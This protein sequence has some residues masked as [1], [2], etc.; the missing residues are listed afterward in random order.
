[1]NENLRNCPH[2]GA[3]MRLIATHDE[4]HPVE[5]WATLWTAYSFCVSCGMRTGDFPGAT[6][7]EVR[8]KAADVS[9][10]RVNEAAFEMVKVEN[11]R[12]IDSEEK[13]GVLEK[14]RDEWKSKVEKLEKEIKTLS[15]IEDQRQMA[16]SD[17]D[18]WKTEAAKSWEV[19]ATLNTTAE[20]KEK[21]RT[22]L[23]KILDGVIISLGGRPEI[24]LPSFWE[25]LP[26]LVKKLKGERD[27]WKAKAEK[28]QIYGSDTTIRCE[29]FEKLLDGVAEAIKETDSDR[30]CSWLDLPARVKQLR[31]EHHLACQYAKEAESKR[32][33][34]YEEASVLSKQLIATK[35]ERD[36]WKVKAEKRFFLRRSVESQK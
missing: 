26:D 15:I 9:N 12:A 11:Q 13:V 28:S 1:M 36:D 25:D 34:L 19:I 8:R 30:V 22:K 21:F 33:N 6:Q 14:E 24:C 3:E 10:R 35:A 32:I 29:K 18:K 31:N 2:C 7:D 23:V 17:R 5:D 4:R 27:E 20:E 16:V